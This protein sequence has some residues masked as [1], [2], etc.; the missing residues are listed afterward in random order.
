MLSELGKFLG[1][2]TGY[3]V[4]ETMIVV[5]GILYWIWIVKLAMEK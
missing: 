4:F 1:Q 3:N 5:G 2:S